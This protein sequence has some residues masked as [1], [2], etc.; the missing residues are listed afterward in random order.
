MKKISILVFVLS[1]LFF[2]CSKD[3]NNPAGGNTGGNT[4]TT[5][6][7]SI[8][9][10]SGAIPNWS[11]G[12]GYIL[13]FGFSGSSSYGMSGIDN[14]GN[15]NVGP[16]QTPS[17]S[18]LF[19]L[20]NALTNAG[21]AGKIIMSDEGLK[22]SPYAYLNVYKPDETFFMAIYYGN[23]THFHSYL[24]ADRNA[25]L[26][27]NVTDGTFTFIYTC[28]VK[29][30]WNRLTVYSGSTTAEFTNNIMPEAVWKWQN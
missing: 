22:I 28:S 6:E 17:S 15:F 30:G 9:S 25:T 12:T 27:I 26:D 7:P 18:V 11:F 13:R 23:N 14:T 10:L 29:K 1:L 24:Y 20:K 16:L 21:Y 5:E 8:T 2:G 3:E 4:G 19:T